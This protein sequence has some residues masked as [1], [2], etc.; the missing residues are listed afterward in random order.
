[1]GGGPAGQPSFSKCQDKRLDGDLDAEVQG[2]EGGRHAK[3]G[4]KRGNWKSL[5]GKRSHSRT[6][7]DGT[8]GY[9][10]RPMGRQARRKT[11]KPNIAGPCR[12]R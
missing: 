6:L 4:N 12:P 8:R 1:M 10:I 9:S 2:Q 7:S 5:R 11:W 3:R